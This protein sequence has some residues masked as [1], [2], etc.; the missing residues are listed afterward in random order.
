MLLTGSEVYHIK[1]TPVRVAGKNL[2]NSAGSVV[3][4]NIK[5]LYAIMCSSRH[6]VPSKAAIFGTFIFFGLGV[7]NISVANKVNGQRT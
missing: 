3:Y 6:D 4:N 1:A 7:A 2:H 5:F